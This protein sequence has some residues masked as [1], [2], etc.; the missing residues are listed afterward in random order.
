MSENSK[1][2]PEG[3]PRAVGLL[4]GGVIGGGWA[5]RFLLNGV[6]VRLYGPSPSAVERV[7][8]MLANARRAY[9]RLTEAPLPAEGAMTVVD[10]VEEAVRE[11]DLV[12]ESVPERLELKQQLLATASSAAVPG[13]LIC[14]STSGFRPS[15]LQAEMDNPECLLVAHPFQP[16]YMLP[17]V[18]LCAGQRT[19]PEMVERA[20]AIFRAVGMHPL[21]VRKEVDGFIANRLNESI[22]REALWLVHDDVATLGEIDDAIR[23]S[24]ALRRA[25]IGSHR[26]VNGAAGMRDTIER[27]A[28]KWPWSRI[29]DKPEIDRAFIDKVAEQ[30]DA[31]VQADPLPIHPEQ[32]RDDLLV[33]VLHALRSQDYGPGKT[34]ACWEQ[35]LRDRAPGP[36]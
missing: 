26:V 19:A 22:S 10:S 1:G 36:N 17:L 7:R 31:I 33:A 5:A 34:L 27:W 4:G 21:V 29:T 35:R 2:L 23:F 16:V 14:S 13:T 6:D 9:Q 32:K 30:A 24:W 12:Q 15:L 3:L 8:R 11:V 28:F 25:A 20:A 18:E